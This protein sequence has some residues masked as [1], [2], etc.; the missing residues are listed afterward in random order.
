M[1]D[2]NKIVELKLGIDG[3]AGALIELLKAATSYM[4]VM[5]REREVELKVREEKDVADLTK[6]VRLKELRNKKAQFDKE[7]T[8]L[9]RERASLEV[10]VTRLEQRKLALLGKDTTVKTELKSESKPVVPQL[11]EKSEQV[12]KAEGNQRPDKSLIQKFPPLKELT[13]KS[14]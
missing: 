5:K 14:E 12:S 9:N 3:L 10:E 6:E 8:R 13:G 7:T 4:H 11:A 2:G 1:S